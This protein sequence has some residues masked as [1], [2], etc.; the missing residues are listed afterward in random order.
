MDFSLTEEQVM[1][2][3]MAWQ[4]AA[5]SI[6]P[7]VTDDDTAEHFPREIIGQMAPLGLLGSIVP[8]GYGGS[9][10]DYISHAIITEGIARTSLSIALSIFGGH[11]V[12]EEMVMTWGSEQQRQRYLP[13]MC[14]GELFGCC[15]LNE[16]GVGA[17]VG[18]FGSRAELNQGWWVI[19]GKKVFIINGGVAN[20]ILAVAE[21]VE[22]GEEQ[23]LGAFLITRDVAGFSSQDITNKNGL[24]ACNI[25]DVY[26][27]DCRVPQENLL[28][29]IEDGNKIVESLV[30]GINFSIAASCVGAAQ[31]CVDASI[32]YAEERQA[33][34][35][36]IG[37]FD[38]IQE[39]IANMI[40]GTEA[41]R[42]L[43]YQVADL[44][45]RKQPFSKQL[46]MA[47]YLASD[48]AIRATTDAILVHGAYG[49]AKDL[50]LERYLRDVAEV[51]EDGGS[52]LIHKLAVARHA[53]GIS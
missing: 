15:A 26:F 30:H 43:T 38:M 36:T 52:P 4:F 6:E 18:D 14:T 21:V 33:F 31:A 37:N 28:G 47:R 10:L 50:P 23:G 8:Q 41:A 11:S 19:N 40:I 9:G 7:A 27:R 29:S 12:V 22:N 17:D 25:A 5:K 3:N 44:K 24:R 48:A 42:L 13:L 34:G 46:A 16:P 32:K 1:V 20:L 49:F 51:I 53:L 45:T 2:R 39:M 35:R